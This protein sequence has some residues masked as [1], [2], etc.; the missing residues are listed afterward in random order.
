MIQLAS[1]LSAVWWWAGS[2][3]PG[4]MHFFLSFL[5]FCFYK[6]RVWTTDSVVN[7]AVHCY[8]RHYPSMHPLS[9]TNYPLQGRGVAG[10]YPSWH[11]LH[12]GQV[13]S[14]SDIILYWFNGLHLKKEWESLL[15]N[16]LSFIEL[17]WRLI[18][19]DKIQCAARIFSHV[20]Q[21]IKA[22]LHPNTKYVLQ[23]VDKIPKQ[24]L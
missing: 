1:Y 7:I 13:G 15:G 20:A 24:V 9:I 21:W 12:P 4:L 3:V 23:W 17:T 11:W 8:F 6:T 14:I 10:A 18:T 19:A 5:F 16:R 2:T 22:L